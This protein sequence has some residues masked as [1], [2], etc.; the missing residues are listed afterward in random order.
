MGDSWYTPN[1]Q[2]NKVIGEYEKRIFYSTEK[3]LMDF[4]AK[5][6]LVST[7]ISVIILN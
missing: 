4:L 7:R 1:T 5:P 2:I 6:V 3:K